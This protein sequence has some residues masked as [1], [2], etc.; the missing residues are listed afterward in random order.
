[1]HEARTM[2]EP[3]GFRQRSFRPPATVPG[4][5]PAMLDRREF[6]YEFILAKLSELDDAVIALDARPDAL[7]WAADRRL[8]VDEAARLAAALAQYERPRTLN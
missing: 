7:A 1:M 5:E 4:K 3:W 8:L 6:E 2:L